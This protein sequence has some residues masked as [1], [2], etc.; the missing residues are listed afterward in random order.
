[1][2]L[3][4]AGQERAQSVQ[5][6]RAEVGA[7]QDARLHAEAGDPPQ[8]PQP[9]QHVQPGPLVFECFFF[10]L[11][12]CVWLL[13]VG[14]I[15]LN[16]LARPSVDAPV[17]QQSMVAGRAAAAA[18]AGVGGADDL[19]FD[20]EFDPL[21]AQQIRQLSALKARAVESMFHISLSL[22][23]P[24]R[25]LALLYFSALCYFVRRAFLSMF[26]LRPPCFL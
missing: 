26:S 21:T 22:T 4:V 7:V 14:F 9:V 5:G 17:Q 3:H 8:P 20:V 25:L 12:I 10:C 2:Q 23:C 18:A 24:Y 19:Q 11:F 15:A 1:M 6:A 16:V 13:Q